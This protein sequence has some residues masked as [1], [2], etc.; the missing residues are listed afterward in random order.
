MDKEGLEYLAEAAYGEEWSLRS[1]SACAKALGRALGGQCAWSA[2]R[3]GWGEFRLFYF[4]FVLFLL[5]SWLVG[6]LGFF[7]CWFCFG[8]GFG[9]LV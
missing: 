7:V 3:V 1:G 2:H 8:F 4:S 5:N 6:L 9:C